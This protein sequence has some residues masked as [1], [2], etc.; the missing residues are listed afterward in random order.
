MGHCCPGSYHDE[1]RISIRR[2]AGEM[3]KGNDEVTG[4]R[5][6]GLSVVQRPA[7]KSPF[8]FLASQFGGPGHKI[9]PGI[10]VVCRKPAA[11]FVEVDPRLVIVFLSCPRK[12]VH[13]GKQRFGQVRRLGLFHVPS[14]KHGTG[15]LLLHPQVPA[16]LS[17]QR[18]HRNRKPC[19]LATGWCCKTKSP[20]RAEPL[21]V[22]RSDIGILLRSRN[23][24]SPIRLASQ[25]LRRQCQ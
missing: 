1:R 12:A 22:S 8:D 23:G 15:Q 21:M 6:Y 10:T 25:G 17:D 2:K 5:A 19:T 24:S 20:L 13:Q 9:I 7:F 14:S 18:L 11:Q 4:L 3:E 16:D